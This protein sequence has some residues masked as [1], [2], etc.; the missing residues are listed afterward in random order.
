TNDGSLFIP[1][2]IGVSTFELYPAVLELLTGKRQAV[3]SA[4][5][6]TPTPP[7]VRWDEDWRLPPY[8]LGAARPDRNILVYFSSD[9]SPLCD[10][11]NKK[12][13]DTSRPFLDFAWKNL[14][15]VKLNLIKDQKPRPASKLAE[16]Q[17][18]L[19]EMNEEIRVQLMK[20]F[21]ITGYPTFVLLNTKT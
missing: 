21:N 20:Q 9:Q 18:A 10:K 6:P 5:L 3:A 17:D 19:D 11:M 4:A 1:K 7:P 15:P 13:I 16:A 12:V 14:Y 2:D 8:F